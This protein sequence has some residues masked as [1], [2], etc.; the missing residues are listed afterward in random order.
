MLNVKVVCMLYIYSRPKVILHFSFLN[1]SILGLILSK[2]NI[3]ISF[4]HFSTHNSLKTTYAR[5][6]PPGTC[7]F[8]K[9]T[10]SAFSHKI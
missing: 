1:I 2:W 5:L 7:A 3:A 8:I 6:L 9:N 4:Q 10:K